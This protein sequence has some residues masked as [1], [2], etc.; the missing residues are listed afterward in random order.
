MNKFIHTQR[1][2]G[3]SLI[4]MLVYLALFVSLSALMV[5][6]LF[7]FQETLAIKRVE[8]AVSE[9]ARTVLE[10]VLREIRDSSA[11]QTGAT[12]TGVAS[13]ELAL[14]QDGDTVRFVQSAN[15]L[16]YQENGVVL[17]VMQPQ[18]VRITGFYVYPY[19]TG[20]IE[21]VRVRMDIEAT[22]AN[23][24]SNESFYGSAVLRGS[25]E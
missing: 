17:E 21:L 14:D 3:F 11:V 13:G 15:S 1:Q 12:V 4:E 18:N 2:R 8:R 23:I 10:T 9:S 16:T 24:T 20:Q 6:M 25:Y 19:T 22:Y 5:S 7:S